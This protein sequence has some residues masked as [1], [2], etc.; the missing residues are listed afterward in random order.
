VAQDSAPPV[1]E[2]ELGARADEELG[3]YDGGAAEGAEESFVDDDAL[4]SGANSHAVSISE[5]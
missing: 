5:R 3:F 1:F 2:L 4:A